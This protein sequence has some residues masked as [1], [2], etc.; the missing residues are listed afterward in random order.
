MDF[1][2]KSLLFFG[3]FSNRSVKSWSAWKSMQH[4][5]RQASNG[6]SIIFVQLGITL[7]KNHDP[8]LSS[9]AGFG[10]DRLIF[11]VDWNEVIHNNFMKNASKNDSGHVN[12]V[13]IHFE[14]RENVFDSEIIFCQCWDGTEEV[15]I[16]QTALE[17][18]G[19]FN[20][21]HNESSIFQYLRNSFPSDLTCDFGDKA[22]WSVIGRKI[23]VSP[24]FAWFLVLL[25]QLF[26]VWFLNFLDDDLIVLDE[27]GQVGLFLSN[28]VL[29]LKPD[30]VIDFELISDEIGSSA[31]NVVHV[32][33]LSVSAVSSHG[34]DKLENIRKALNCRYFFEAF[35]GV[36]P[37]SDL[38]GTRGT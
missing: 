5:I 16:A 6:F 26:V 15:T 7:L 4:L 36:S 23:W 12:S 9:S 8:N 1:I 10:K 32:E 22:N 37:R 28:R 38:P 31:D 19:W 14:G 24:F 21:V 13:W 17:N 30:K 33:K 3:I 11:G 20:L 2:P 29:R 18:V 34:I 35:V 27:L 25:N